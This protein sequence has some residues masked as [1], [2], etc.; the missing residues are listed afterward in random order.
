MGFCT[1]L[2]RCIPALSVLLLLVLVEC[3]LKV[4]E[5][6][7]IIGLGYPTGLIRK[8][9][10]VFAQFLFIAYSAFLH[11]LALVFPF[12]LWH[13]ISRATSQIE[14]VHRQG[15]DDVLS[16]K[17]ATREDAQDVVAAGPDG[18]MDTIHAIMLPSY[19]EDIGTLEDTLKVLAGHTLAMTCYDV[20]TRQNHERN[21]HSLMPMLQLVTA[22]KTSRRCTLPWRQET[23][24]Q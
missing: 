18:G 14:A 10:P 3:A 22:T 1:W 24:T 8:P 11:V 2:L 15:L 23:P 13:S 21:I 17:S 4:F 9:N 6:E 19:K 12:R 7:Y 5:T 20:R 16:R